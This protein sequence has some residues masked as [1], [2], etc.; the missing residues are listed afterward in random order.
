MDSEPTCPKYLAGTK[1]PG[2]DNKSAHTANDGCLVATMRRA[3]VAV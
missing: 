1:R 2:G 3:R